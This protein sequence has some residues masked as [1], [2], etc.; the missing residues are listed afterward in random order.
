MEINNSNYYSKE[1]SQEYFSVSQ[2]KS[3]MSC[4]AR[5]MAE[6]NGEYERPATRALLV[7]SFVDRYFEGTLDEFMRENPG[8]YTRRR[9]LR[10]E[11]KRANQ[12]IEIVKSDPKFMSSMSGEKQRIFTFE[13]FGEKWKAKLDSYNPGIAITDLKV[14]AKMDTL[15]IWRYDLQG[16][17]YQKGVEICTGEKLPFY[18]AVV[19]KEKVLDR[20]IWQIP[21]TTL[22]FALAQVERDI[23]HFADVKAGRI[24]PKYCGKCDYCKSIKKA[25]VRNYNELLEG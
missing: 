25:R 22:D 19:T 24:E 15:P 4:E 11:F 1:A 5:T 18:L 2:F 17:I 20:D 6:I 12:I 13:L 21:Q 14:V 16:A 8:I 9:E 3:F 23:D 7:G 10:A